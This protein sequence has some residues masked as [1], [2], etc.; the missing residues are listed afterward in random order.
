MYIHL[1]FKQEKTKMNNYEMEKTEKVKK[2][3]DRL[4]NLIL[5]KVDLYNA[6]YEDIE[7]FNESIYYMIDTLKPLIR[8]G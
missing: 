1:I 3:L 2:E 6:A 4:Q 7:S 5:T 8:E